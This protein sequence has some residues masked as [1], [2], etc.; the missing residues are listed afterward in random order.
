[1]KTQMQFFKGEYKVTKVKVVFRMSVAGC[2]DPNT[3]RLDEEYEAIARRHKAMGASA[4]Y[5][6]LVIDERKRLDR[7]DAKATG[8]AADFSFRLDDVAEIPEDVADKWQRSGIC[9]ILTESREKT[10]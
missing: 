5:T 9:K 7:Y 6:A 1:V 8:F 4:K 3:A 10:A 2:G